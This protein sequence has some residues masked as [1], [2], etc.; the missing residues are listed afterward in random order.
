MLR[1]GLPLWQSGMAVALLLFL[2]LAAAGPRESV[3]ALGMVVMGFWTMM[4]PPES[5]MPRGIML[6]V[7][8][9]LL[10]P[11]LSFLPSDL[12]PDQG[13][14]R[15]LEETGIP[16]GR[17]LSAQPALSLSVVLWQAA[18]GLIALRLVAGGHRE[19]NHGRILV[20][21]VLALLVYGGLSMLRPILIPEVVFSVET[22]VPEFGFF[23]NHNHTATLLAV[24][25]VL[26]LGVLLHGTNRRKAWSVVVG[27]LG[28][29]LV[30]Y[31]LVFFNVSRAGILLAAIGAL[32]LLLL[33]GVGRKRRNGRRVLF[34][35]LLLGSAV[36]YAADE[37]VKKR[38]LDQREEEVQAE[39][40][41][42]DLPADLLDARWD[43]FRD[44]FVLIGAQPLTGVGA[45]QFADSYPQYQHHSVREAGSRHVHPESSWLWAASEGGGLL[46]LA[47]LGLVVVIFARCWRRIRRG[48]KRGLRPALLVAGALPFVHGLVDVPLHRESIFWLSALLV[49]LA[50][51]DGLGI[52]AKARWM[53][54]GFGAVVSVLGIL[55]LAGVLAVPSQEAEGHL[56]KARALLKEDA[57]L[58]ESGI[59]SEGQDPLEAALEELAL[60]T[61]WRPLDGRIH[62]LM[63]NL[64]LYFD[65]KD[66][67]ARV[68]FLRERT[69][70][71]GSAMVPYR[72][73]MSWI[74]INQAET[75]L[76]WGEALARAADR[77]Q[78]EE[79]LFKGILREARLRPALRQF[80][81]GVS[82]Q[83]GAL[84][85]LLMQGWPAEILREEEDGI[86]SALQQL[87]DGEL[88][89]S[90]KDLVISESQNHGESP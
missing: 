7:M 67:E 13:W 82:A 4:C 73:G 60:A 87:G 76:L 75:A 5:R 57:K 55:V 74:E 45:G 90:F 48:G 41:G 27:V 72:Q 22:G 86:S 2:W 78:L 37:G 32:S 20:M 71:P 36:F 51:P 25:L 68:S 9:C 62:A 21:I 83:R 10:L 49:G 39:Q 11:L 59:E 28:I 19:E 43:I 58:V 64:A 88:L 47:L 40:A 81:I 42:R 63:G 53:W 38:L 16:L 54:R 12:G 24:G 26:S 34:L 33:Y 30:T 89:K 31:W 6:L 80:C 3:A 46:A 85:G 70:N 84:A 79:A 50:S 14:R 56:D 52:G 1:S 61:S 65:D 18:V 35:A 17:F 8:G 29:L 66:E 44:T 23:P 77:P 15:D 69:L